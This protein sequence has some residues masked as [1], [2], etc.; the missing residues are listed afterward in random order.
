MGKTDST[1]RILPSG[2]DSSLSLP[3]TGILVDNSY[4]TSLFSDT[5]AHGTCL[6][7]STWSPSSPWHSVALHLGSVLVCENCQVSFIPINLRTSTLYPLSLGA[8][9]QPLFLAL[10]IF[11]SELDT[12]LQSLCVL[13]NHAGGL[14]EALV[15]RFEW[16]ERISLAYDDWD[17]TLAAFSLD[18][19]LLPLFT[20]P[21]LIRLWRWIQWDSRIYSLLCPLQSWQTWVRDR[22]RTAFARLESQLTPKQKTT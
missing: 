6:S 12:E 3:H 21:T 5:A 22:L 9:I 15:S 2:F 8:N 10:Q 17:K 20:F 1:G 11:H 7:R 4:S 19:C 18:P 16:G 13:G 14:A